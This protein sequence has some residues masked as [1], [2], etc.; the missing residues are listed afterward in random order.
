MQKWEYLYVRG[1]NEKIDWINGTAAGGR[2]E[3]W[4][5]LNEMGQEGW[6]LISTWIES[7]WKYL[8]LKRPVGESEQ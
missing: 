3:I 5:F 2:I 8:I 7:S 1:H 4:N 6:E